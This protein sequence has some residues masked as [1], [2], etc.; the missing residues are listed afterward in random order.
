MKNKVNILG[1]DYKIEVRKFSE[2]DCLKR[3]NWQGYC[4]EDLKLIVLADLDEKEHFQYDSEEQKDKSIKETL[5]HEIIHAFLN[6]SGLSYSA[7][8]YQ[9]AWAKNEEMVDWIAI[10][11][12]KIAKVYKELGIM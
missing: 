2:D 9:G 11:F 10:Q 12:P 8:Q 3:N 1:T 7:L 5:R 6:E 4:D